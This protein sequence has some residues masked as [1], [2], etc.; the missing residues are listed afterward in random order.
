MLCSSQFPTKF[1]LTQMAWYKTVRITIYFRIFQLRKQR[2][3]TSPF[4]EC[5]RAKR[6]WQ[7]P[8]FLISHKTLLIKDIWEILMSPSVIQTMRFQSLH[9]ICPGVLVC[10]ETTVRIQHPSCASWDTFVSQIG[11]WQIP[12]HVQLLGSETCMIYQYIPLI[13][14][15]ISTSTVVDITFKVRLVYSFIL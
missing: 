15:G 9:D 8:R 12:I 2:D 10:R 14:S 6:E 1:H 13:T 7:P 11:T 4:S 5:P 3:N